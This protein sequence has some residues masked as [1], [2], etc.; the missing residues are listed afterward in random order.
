MSE[1]SVSKNVQIT[2]SLM[3][4][5]DNEIANFR[6]SPAGKRWNLNNPFAP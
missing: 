6:E 1:N 5:I 4:A 3:D 2:L